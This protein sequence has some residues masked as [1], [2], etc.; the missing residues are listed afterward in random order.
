MPRS[1]CSALHGVS[2]NLKKPNRLGKKGSVLTKAKE[3]SCKIKFATL[4]LK[5]V[6][7]NWWKS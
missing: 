5:A 2:P 4:E 1:G 3:R 7:T 6:G